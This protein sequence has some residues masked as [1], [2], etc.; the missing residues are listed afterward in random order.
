MA[1]EIKN[2]Q[3][4]FRCNAN[5][6]AMPETEGGRQCDKCQKKVHDFTNSKAEEF[7]RILAENNYNI[8]GRFKLEQLAP[9]SLPLWKK[10]L[11]A[12]MVLIGFNWFASK[13]HAQN[14]KATSVKDTTRS[15]SKATV[16]STLN[17]T[18]SG[19][20]PD[21]IF[22][23]F[24]ILPKPPAN[25]QDFLDKNLDKKKALTP[26]RLVLTFVIETDGSLSDIHAI[27]KYQDEGAV[28]EAIRIFKLSPKWTP[29]Q[30]LDKVV[31]VQYTVPIFFN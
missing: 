26:G 6:E 24:E 27:G 18:S 31:R 21:G 20:F 5:W 28:N 16:S 19:K 10:W 23:S 11:S 30:I 15:S 7:E 9:P 2:V 4:Q 14:V 25:F 13:A 8:C 22:G 29:G 1:N 17:G 12:A 3:L